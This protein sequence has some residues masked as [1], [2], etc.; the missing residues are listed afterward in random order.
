MSQYGLCDQLCQDGENARVSPGISMRRLESL[1]MVQ[2]RGGQGGKTFAETTPRGF[3]AFPQL[4]NR[5][6]RRRDVGII[7][8][9]RH[10]AGEFDSN[11]S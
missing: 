1:C 9:G 6:H 10:H 5:Q 8:P 11:L 3:A 4:G 7:R 2:C